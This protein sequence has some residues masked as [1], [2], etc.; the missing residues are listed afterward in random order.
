[1]RDNGEAQESVSQTEAGGTNTSGDTAAS[2]TRYLTIEIGGKTV[3]RIPLG[4][5]EII[6]DIPAPVKLDGGFSIGEE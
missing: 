2:P 4:Q 6:G 5:P 3:I 1:M